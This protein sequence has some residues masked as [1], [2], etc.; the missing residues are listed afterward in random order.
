MRRKI[1]IR[2]DDICPTMD[3]GQ[4]E[5]AVSVLEACDVKP[6]LG[7]IP[8]C[9][10][11]EL[12]ISEAREDFWQYIKS[13]QA[14]GYTV[15]MHGY[16]HV[17]DTKARGLVSA[18]QASEFAGHTYKEQFEKLKSG[19]KILR[20]HGI[21]TDI[22]FA[23][24]HS[25]DLNTLKAL[26]ALGFKFISD[27]MS[28]T[29]IDRFG[30]AC[31]PCRSGGVPRIGKCGYYTAVF[32][33]HEWA[34]PDKA[35]E[36]MKLKRLCRMYQSDIV[37]FDQY[38]DRKAGGGIVPRLD[39][40]M[41][42]KFLYGA[43]PVLSEIR[44]KLKKAAGCGKEETGHM[45]MDRLLQNGVIRKIFRFYFLR[46][47]RDTTAFA[48]LLGVR[49]G[50][51]GQILGDPVAI[52]GTEPW[53]ITL[54]NHVDVTSGVSF[55]NHEGGIW[56]ARG[57]K[58]ELNTYDKFSPIRVGNNVMIG[59]GSLIMP[60][61]TIGDNVIIAG[62]SV[63]TKDIPSN[64]IVGGCPAKRISDLGRFLERLEDGLVPTK[65]MTQHQKRD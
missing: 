36:Y 50:T 34:R 58:P 1:L 42:L 2:F 30:V 35:E 17:F 53:L 51:G 9:R 47:R 23:P 43:R 55:L 48:R 32:H 64:S 22:F 52:F 6:L 14:K 41:Y 26:G 3:W 21:E 12:F 4:W 37:S 13:L 33:A 8:D 27:G 49:V 15:A 46:I 10:D 44:Q 45:E 40:W 25:Y 62:H 7:V 61:V 39:E 20:S 56:V 5:R 24:A 11:P 38:N 60:G 54:G 29:P 65:K 57:M 19:R 28:Q 31:L 59:T 16:Q 63:I 18:R